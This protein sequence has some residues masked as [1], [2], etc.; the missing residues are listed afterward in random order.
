MAWSDAGA[1]LATA[2]PGAPGPPGAEQQ[3]PGEQAAAQPEPQA[4][5][6]AAHGVVADVLQHRGRHQRPQLAPQ[7]GA[8][9]QLHAALFGR[10]QRAR[11]QRAERAQ[12]AG[13]RAAHAQRR[14]ELAHV[15][16]AQ[17]VGG[18]VLVTEQHPLA[19]VLQHELRRAG[20]VDF[21]GRP[22]IAVALQRLQHQRDAI[23]PLHGR[24]CL[25]A[26]FGFLLAAAADAE[27]GSRG[28]EPEQGHG[29]CEQR[30]R[31]AA[32]PGTK[33]IDEP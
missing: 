6:R 29:D 3:Q 7:G 21:V 20:L 14:R 19:L 16:L 23:A 22:R 5:A 8:V 25:D 27:P 15:G 26:Q 9:E 18:A 28:E 31:Q 32:A 10:H 17:A 11:L 1:L 13:T 4:V 33:G 12:H 2:V 24:Q 30:H